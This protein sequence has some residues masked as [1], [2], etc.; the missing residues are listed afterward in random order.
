MGELGH[1]DADHA[2]LTEVV[3]AEAGE[4]VVQVV[5]G[6]HAVVDVIRVRF[7]VG[8]ELGLRKEVDVVAHRLQHRGIG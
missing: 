2:Q 4:N 3:E 5:G 6:V 1:A 8:V 7:Q